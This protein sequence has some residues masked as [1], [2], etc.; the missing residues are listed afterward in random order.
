MRDEESIGSRCAVA[1]TL[2]GWSQEA[3]AARAGVSAS[4]LQSV[5]Q[6]RRVASPDF[7]TAVATALQVDQARLTG[8]PYDEVVE[9]GSIPEIRRAILRYDVPVDPVP[10]ARDLAV[11]QTDIDKVSRLRQAARLAELGE[12]VPRLLNELQYLVAT[13]AGELRERAAGMLATTYAAAGQVAYKWGYAD[14]DSILVDRYRWAAA[15][16]GDPLLMAIADW[17]RAGQHM[18]VGSYTSGLRIIDTA[19]DALPGQTRN[20]RASPP[21]SATSS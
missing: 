8:Q 7:V 1:R 6:G 3:L 16:S 17:Q 19:L 12:L 15:L 18:M 14:L 5:E 21:R 9:H 2:K 10:P 20:T 13:T 11:I 4:L